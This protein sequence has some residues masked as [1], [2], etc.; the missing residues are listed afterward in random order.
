MSE[1]VGG[2]SS[3]EVRIRKVRRVL[4]RRW[5]F[6]WRGLVPLVGLA[7]LLLY[8]RSPFAHRV[9][10]DA[11][12]SQVEAE[13]L[14][15]GAGWAHAS[16]SGQHVVLEGEEPSPG[17]G[18]VALA[19]A[20][21]ALCPTWAGLLV[22][23]TR[24]EGSFRAPPAATALA[25][26]GPSAVSPPVWPALW[27]DRD[28]NGLALR[29]PVPDAALHARLVAAGRAAL[30]ADPRQ[31]VRDQLSDSGTAAPEGFEAL[32]LR[33]LET[34][35]RCRSGQAGLARGVLTL[36][37]E[38]ARAEVAPVR[39]AL[40]RPPAAGSVGAIEL[41][42]AEEVEGCE[43]RLAQALAHATI[44]FE[45]DSAVIGASATAL[46]DQLAGAARGC[47]GTLRVEGHTDSQGSAERNVQLSRERAQAV[48]RA[49]EVR[50]LPAARLLAHGY[51]AA[52]PLGT[53]D[54]A[55]GRARNRRIEVHVVRY[56]AR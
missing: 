11:V 36:R 40:A 24:V 35:A 3:R 2:S 14:R 20:R 51:G 28:E 22:C 21:Q 5:P 16:V 38:L 8:A 55:E 19:A 53:N 52:R 23:A 10:E 43:Q 4:P 31:S 47:P 29:G 6:V 33:A 56:G 9:V 41:L 12:R 32:A 44:E 17:A 27:I 15:R 54:T 46:L 18:E 25:G 48:K 30:P 50:G 7:L 13:L 49:L 45:Q 26:A 34:A 39:Q 42:V 1:E 37:C